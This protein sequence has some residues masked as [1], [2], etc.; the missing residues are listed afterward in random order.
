MCL[1]LVHFYPSMCVPSCSGVT[2]MFTFVQFCPTTP[3][4]S[5]KG[6]DSDVTPKAIVPSPSSPPGGSLTPVL[7]SDTLSPLTDAPPSPVSSLSSLSELDHDPSA[8]DSEE[9]ASLEPPS[10]TSREVKPP[11]SS[12][13]TGSKSN[14]TV[15]RPVTG[16]TS[17]GRERRV[18]IK[19]RG[20]ARLTR[21]SAT[22][23]KRETGLLQRDSTASSSFLFDFLCTF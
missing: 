5:S 4:A 16:F 23:E 8:T 15:I 6:Q 1:L 2:I 3:T 19:P 20:S 21:S 11:L 14:H 18:I 12:R 7:S 10:R 17:T 9:R 22:R 13:I